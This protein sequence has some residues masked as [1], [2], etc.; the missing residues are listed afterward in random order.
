MKPASSTTSAG[1]DFNPF[2]ISALPKS[3]VERLRLP[4]SWQK[5]LPSA[6]GSSASWEEG[7][8]EEAQAWLNGPAGSGDTSL[9]DWASE[10]DENLAAARSKLRRAMT[11]RKARLAAARAL[12]DLHR[13]L[14]EA[15]FASTTDRQWAALFLKS[16]QAKC[17]SPAA[18]KG[19]L[20][21][22]KKSRR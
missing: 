14:A 13:Q 3:W 22:I 2:M 21:I 10:S 15:V 8:G 16:W 5:P 11:A 9:R 1:Y 17:D 18:L 20:A 12:A 7:L 6:G 19:I 4:A